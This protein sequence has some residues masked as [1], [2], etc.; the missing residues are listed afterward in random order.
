VQN[1]PRENFTLRNGTFAG[2]SQNLLDDAKPIRSKTRCS[3]LHL[4]K[5]LKRL[6][7]AQGLEPWTR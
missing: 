3:A 7:G 5:L 6:V 1:W 4:P 2:M